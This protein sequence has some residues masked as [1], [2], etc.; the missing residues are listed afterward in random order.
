MLTLFFDDPREAAVQALSSDDLRS[1]A[2]ALDAI[3]IDEK[4][5]F[6]LVRTVTEADSS[7]RALREIRQCLGSQPAGAFER[8]VLLRAWLT[9]IERVPDLRVPDAV[10]RMLYEEV[11]LVAS[12][13]AGTLHRFS[14]DQNAFAAL[15]KL[16]TLRRFPAGQLS[17][18]VSGFPRSWLARGRARTLPRVLYYLG[19]R[20]RG[21]RP[22]F[23]IHLNANRKDRA[24]LLERES[25][26]SYFRMAQAMAL[27]PEIKGLLASSWLHSPDTMAVSPHLTGLNR[28]FLEYGALVTTMGPA[29]P[30]SGV[31]VRSPERKRLFEQGLFKPTTGLVIWPRAQVLAWAAAHPE[32]GE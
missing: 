14:V 1:T 13:R 10:K 2:S 22:A 17:W 12:P 9:S 19:V 7:R 31:F 3:G 20:M 16:A 5:C 18:E 30:E 8:V 27:Q 6:D 4:A 29:D 28:V 11:R 24:A 21:F 25:N 32:F 23:F 26:R 15:S